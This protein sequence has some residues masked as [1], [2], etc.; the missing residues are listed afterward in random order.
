MKLCY[1]SDGML[2][3][4]NEALRDRVMTL[5]KKVQSQEDEIVCLKSALSDV[6]RRLQI[7]E[8]GSGK[9]EYKSL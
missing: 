9:M 3:N 4:E 8:T 1:I 2:D 7:V 6:I 5:E